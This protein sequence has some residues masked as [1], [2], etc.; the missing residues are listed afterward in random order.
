MRFLIIF[1]LTYRG[2]VWRRFDANV[3]NEVMT[4][5]K[6]TSCACHVGA[7]MMMMIFLVREPSVCYVCE[8]LYRLCAYMIRNYI[9]LAYIHFIMIN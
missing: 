2:D 9:I 4:V 1:L 8:L 5:R 7:M 6:L 3:A